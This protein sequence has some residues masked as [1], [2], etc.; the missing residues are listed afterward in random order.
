MDNILAPDLGPTMEWAMRK[1]GKISS[2][3]MSFKPPHFDNVRCRYTRFK[4]WLNGNHVVLHSMML[5]MKPSDGT[6]ARKLAMV[7]AM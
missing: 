4:R 3:S 2:G 6:T 5:P 7:A 1:N